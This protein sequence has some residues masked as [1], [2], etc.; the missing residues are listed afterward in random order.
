MK[1][2]SGKKRALLEI[3]NYDEKQWWI[4][5]PALSAFVREKTAVTEEQLQG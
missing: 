3:V 2:R 5:D 4:K 1:K